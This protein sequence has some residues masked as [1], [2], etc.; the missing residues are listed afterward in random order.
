M[1]LCPLVILTATFYQSDWLHP[2]ARSADMIVPLSTMS[3]DQS[4]IFTVPPAGN[5]SHFFFPLATS[6]SLYDRRQSLCHKTQSRR[7][8]KYKQVVTTKKN[9]GTTICPMNTYLMYLPTR[10]MVQVPSAKCDCSWT[11]RWP[12]LFS[13][14]PCFSRVHL[15]Q[16]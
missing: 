7:S 2:K 4:N 12:E 10:R 8:L 15:C 13:L 9:F 14:T 5:V 3:A 16:P 11:V 6:H 1:I